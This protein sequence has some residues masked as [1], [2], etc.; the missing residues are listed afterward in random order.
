[1][2]GLEI[3][4]RNPDQPH[5]RHRWEQLTRESESSLYEIQEFVFL[6]DGGFWSTTSRLEVLGVAGWRRNATRAEGKRAM[7]T[8]GTSLLK[9]GN[10][11]DFRYDGQS[12][13]QR[14]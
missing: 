1:M 8:T 9:E 3:V 14:P 11:G 5:H 2:A 6:T 13:N 12:A 4:W 10:L 7:T